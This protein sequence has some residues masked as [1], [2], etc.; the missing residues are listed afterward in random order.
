MDQRYRSH[1]A[2]V[3]AELKKRYVV[4][5]HPELMATTK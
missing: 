2:S 4:E 5:T 1:L 3:V